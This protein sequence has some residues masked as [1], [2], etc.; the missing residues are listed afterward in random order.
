MNAETSLLKKE[1][2]E[3]QKSLHKLLL[4]YF[5]FCHFRATPTAY[6]GSQAKGQI[7]AVAT[8]YSHSH[9]HSN[10]RSQPHLQ[11]TPH[12]SQQHQDP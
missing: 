10:M 8:G 12:S 5:A 9:S 3:S 6:G 7:G 2:S 11:P 4:F 1:Y